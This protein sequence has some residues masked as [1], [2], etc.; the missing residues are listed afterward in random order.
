[1][2]TGGDPR[3]KIWSLILMVGSGM[4]FLAFFMPWWSMK[5]PLNPP[6]QRPE[7]ARFGSDEYKAYTEEMKSWSE[8]NKDKLEK[9][10]KVL[11]KNERWYRD[12]LADKYSDAKKSSK[13]GET[14]TVRLWGWSVGV[15][16]TAFIFSFVLL[17]VAIVPIFVK[18][19][20]NWIWTGYFAAAVIGLVLLILSMVWY[21]SSPGENV[22]GML[23]QGVGIQPGPYLN[24]FGSLAILTSGVLGGVFGLLHF[25][26]TLKAGKKAAAEPTAPVIEGEDEFIEE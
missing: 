24:L 5:F 3:L 15:G 7:G 13:D 2:S 17:P 11:N 23:S 1:M 6:P 10:I 14:V 9:S 8:D 20:R 21:F 4:V 16:L 26:K 18:F 22:S 12:K 19:L 25:L